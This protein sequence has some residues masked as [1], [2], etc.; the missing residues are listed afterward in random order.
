MNPVHSIRQAHPNGPFVHP[1]DFTETS[2]ALVL[3][4]QVCYLCADACLAE[5]SPEHLRR[6]I[7]MNLDCGAIC[8]VTASL[9]LRR[10]EMTASARQAQLHA[11]V[12]ACQACAEECRSHASAHQHCAICMQTCLDCQ[13]KCNFA[14]GELSPAVAGAIE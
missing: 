12:V 8:G 6:C 10:T 5:K 1:G 4:A 11:C 2:D 3:C 9:L 7:Q 14:L 13:E